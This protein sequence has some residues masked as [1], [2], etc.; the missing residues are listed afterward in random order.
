MGFSPFTN[1]VSTCTPWSLYVVRKE[2]AYRWRL[3]A[4]SDL[5]ATGE[6]ALAWKPRDRAS[7]D[8]GG[9]WTLESEFKSPDL[10]DLSRV[11]LENSLDLSES[12][13]SYMR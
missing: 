2:E 1:V 5:L 11:S 7:V 8:W 9:T 12:W 13:F 6:A 3:R 10:L 4:V